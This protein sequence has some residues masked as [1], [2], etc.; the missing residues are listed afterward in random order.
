MMHL[1]RKYTT[2]LLFILISSTGM[3]Q[4]TEVVDSL[5][6]S[7]ARAVTIEDKF[8]L[9]EN[10][11][12][13]LMNVNLQEAE[14][15]GN[16]LIRLA[17]ESR[18]RKLMVQAYVSNGI[19]CSYMR[20]QK[21]FMDRSI[22]YFNQALELAKKNRMDEQIGEIQIRLAGIYLTVPDKDKAFSYA[23]QAFSL[24]STLSNDSL[25]AEG[26]NMYGQVYLAR[27]EKS[28]AL[29]NY[30]TALRIA[31]D[32]KVETKADLNRKS[33]VMRHCYLLL[34]DFYSDIGDYDKALDYHTAAFKKLDDIRE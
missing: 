27:N 25:E 5:K 10:L 31:E 26:H 13:V 24:I 6:A 3:T 23:N 20:G 12:R 1:F 32:M 14:K 30:L 19:R 7:L 22:G 28:S 33:I 29:R 16:D 11:S 2:L 34:S 8:F 21:S 18:I 4:Q 9:M 15:C 17:E